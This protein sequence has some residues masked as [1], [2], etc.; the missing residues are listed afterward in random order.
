MQ[1]DASIR[2]RID[3]DLSDGTFKLPL[4]FTFIRFE[5]KRIFHLYFDVNLFIL[6]ERLLWKI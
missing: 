3:I 6:I 5:G 2:A 4:P 1:Y